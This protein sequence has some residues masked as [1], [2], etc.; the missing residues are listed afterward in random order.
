[1]IDDAEDEAEIGEVADEDE[2]ERSDQSDDQEVVEEGDEVESRDDEGA[3]EEETLIDASARSMSYQSDLSEH[4]HHEDHHEHHEEHHEHHGDHHEHHDD[5]HEHHHDHSGPALAVFG[6]TPEGNEGLTAT[7]KGQEKELDDL[8][9][10]SNSLAWK[11]RS[12]EL[13]IRDSYLIISYDLVG[14]EQR[15]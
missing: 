12:I 9:S 3:E 11:V 13:V 10:A 4:E 5:H 7:N 8:S 2:V 15:R 14:V 1:M 6:P